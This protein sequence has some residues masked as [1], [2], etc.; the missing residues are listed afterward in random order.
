MPGAIL[1]HGSVPPRTSS[2]WSSGTERTSR[3][4]SPAFLID[5]PGGKALFDSG[6]H[7]DAGRD[8]DARLGPAARVFEVELRDGEDVAARLGALGVDPAEIRY[9]ITSHLHFD[10]TGGHASIPNA[11]VVVQRRE[12]DAGHDADLM[13]RN[14]FDARNY[15]T[16][17]EV[18]AVDGE[19]DL[20]GDGRVVCLPT[21]GHTPGHQSL[22][23]RLAGGDVVLTADACYLRRTL[24][25]LHLP[26][27]VH[28]PSAM[29]SS[30]H[31]LRALQQAGARIFYGH[32]PEFW[33]TVPQAPAEV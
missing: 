31:R 20:F 13:A 10:H 16:G 24:E 32:D 7:P 3:R 33:A 9:L 2:R 12:W 19:H 8:P 25:E 1:R 28:D 21:Y 5:H 6:L 14:F 18:L 11:R 15:D 29:L 4:A 26:A 30:L 23:V 17:H 27:I 22:R